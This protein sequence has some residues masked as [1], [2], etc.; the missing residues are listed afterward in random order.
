MRLWKICEVSLWEQLQREGVLYY[1][2]SL[3]DGEDCWTKTAYDWMRGQMTK[4]IRGYDGRYPWWAWHTVDGKRK[5]DLRCYVF[6]DWRPREESVRLALDVPDEEVLLSDYDHWHAVLNGSCKPNES[7][8]QS[9]HHISLSVREER[10]VERA[11]RTMSLEQ[12]RPIVERS[13]ERIFLLTYPKRPKEGGWGWGPAGQ[14]RFIQ[15]CFETL[16]LADV[17][18]VTPFNSWKRHD[19]SRTSGERILQV[20]S[21]QKAQAPQKTA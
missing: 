10:R 9:W 7:G 13:W 1:D 12:R 11:F 8:Y 2:A 20:D 17:R 3:L 4:R 6:R 14:S 5:A 21:P 16:R 19:T 18:D 15:A